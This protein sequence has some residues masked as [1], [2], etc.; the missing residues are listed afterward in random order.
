M[1]QSEWIYSA[2]PRLGLRALHYILLIW[3]IRTN[4]YRRTDTNTVVANQKLSYTAVKV[5]LR[6][7]VY[8]KFHREPI[9]TLERCE[10]MFSHLVYSQSTVWRNLEPVYHQC[11]IDIV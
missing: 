2:F 11:T 8:V 1:T 6:N 9:P 3:Q 4:Q 7:N 5:M 10:A